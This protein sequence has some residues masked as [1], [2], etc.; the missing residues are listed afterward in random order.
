[1]CDVQKAAYSK[2]YT[3]RRSLAL[4]ASVLAADFETAV[5]L[6]FRC[7]RAIM[8]AAA[9]SQIRSL[10]V[11]ARQITGGPVRYVQTATY[12]PPEGGPV[13]RLIVQLPADVCEKLRASWFM[14]PTEMEPMT[15][16]KLAEFAAGLMTQPPDTWPEHC[17]TWTCSKDLR[18]PRLYSGACP[19]GLPP[20]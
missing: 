12:E 20:C 4:L 3:R 13:Y 16:A 10:R 7:S 8:P 14:G 15:A 17:A 6:T 9:V 11:R 1:M 5:M 2:A 18:R 19:M